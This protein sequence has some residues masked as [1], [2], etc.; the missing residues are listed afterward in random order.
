MSA[1]RA[2]TDPLQRGPCAGQGS[3]TRRHR[4]P[5]EPLPQRA[6][7]V[8]LR[9]DRR[10]ADG[11]DGAARPVGGGAGG[12]ADPVALGRRGLPGRG[13]PQ[14]RCRS[15]A[16]TWRDASPPPKGRRSGFARSQRAGSTR[17]RNPWRFPNRCRS[18]PGS[19]S[20]RRA[21]RRTAAISLP[22]WRSSAG[23]KASVHRMSSRL[24]SPGW[25]AR[26]NTGS[27]RPQRIEAKRRS[28]TAIMPT[29]AGSGRGTPAETRKRYSVAPVMDAVA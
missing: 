29:R 19:R 7:Y 6:A 20:P 21:S 1:W 28:T 16:A 14:R 17:S 12:G 10:W 23:S 18:G 25:P 11:R 24:P 15:V 22:S 4:D 26:A 3:G 8:R 27:F 2:T 9:G 5:A 13:G